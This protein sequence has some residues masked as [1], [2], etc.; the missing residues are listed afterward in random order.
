[1]FKVTI[2]DYVAEVGPWDK[3]AI[4]RNEG[5]NLV[6]CGKGRWDG[7]NIVDCLAPLGESVYE[8]IDD[9][10]RDEIDGYPL[11]NCGCG[12]RTDRTV[13]LL[14]EHRKG[15]AD[16]LNG[17]NINSLRLDVPCVEGHEDGVEGFV[18]E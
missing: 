2:G 11:C 14:P 9:A 10:I 4:H 12:E 3:V 5:G 17:C 8:A 15:T 6:F 7:W 1:M 18:K 13:R 16:A